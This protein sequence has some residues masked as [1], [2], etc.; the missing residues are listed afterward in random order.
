MVSSTGSIRGL[1]A[2]V[3][4]LKG[5]GGTIVASSIQVAYPIF[6]NGTGMSSSGEKSLE[7]GNWPLYDPLDP[8]PPK[9]VK[10]SV[11]PVTYVTARKF[12]AMQPVWMTVRVPRTAAAGEYRGTVTVEAEGAKPVAAGLEL[13]VVG[14]WVLPDPQAFKTYVGLL[15]CPDAVASYYKVGLWSEQHWKLMDKVF[16]VL[17]QLGTKDLYIPLAAKTHL[18]NPYSMVEWVKQADG[19]YRC[20]THIAERYLDLAIKHMG[21]IPTVC[22]YV[23]T[24][25]QYGFQ[26][27]VDQPIVT[28]MDPATGKLK[29]MLPPKWGTPA[30]RTFWKPVIEKMRG[31]LAKRGLENSMFFGYLADGIGPAEG[32]S[33]GMSNHF[34]DLRAISPQTKW[35]ASSHWPPLSWRAGPT[36]RGPDFLG[37]LSWMWGPLLSVSWMD[38]NDTPWWKPSYGWRD[39][40]VPLTMLA[41]SRSRNPT[42]VNDHCPNVTRWR[43]APEAVLLSK[44]SDGYTYQGF[45]PWGADFWGNECVTFDSYHNVGLSET[46]VRWLVGP[47]QDGPVPSC[48]TRML[49]EGLQEAEV[50]IYVQNALLDPGSK[51]KLGTD[52]A[53]R[54]REACDERTRNFTYMS[55][56]RYSDSAEAMPRQRLIPDVAAWEDASVRLYRLADEV[57]KALAKG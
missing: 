31:I 6:A 9:E 54:C 40:T 57:Q 23:S 16:E 17:G 3:T 21:K 38:E 5:P 18:G 25:S 12:P 44:K 45:G 52:L 35:I 46:P 1:K 55:S 37:A 53:R 50:R 7:I 36:L 33:S 32:N 24:R 42:L 51:A 26:S 47:G 13:E 8:L 19:S 4:D 34:A 41:G 43:V 20:D 48:R 2:H 11:W 15:E 56:F 39:R 14:D 27:A 29:D 49:Q 10:E 22:L 28:E 30:A